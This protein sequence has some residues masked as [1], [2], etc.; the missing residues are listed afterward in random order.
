MLRSRLQN[1]GAAKWG[2]GV[3]LPVP[4]FVTT[5]RCA[6][7]RP[8]TLQFLRLYASAVNEQMLCDIFG[9]N[10]KASFPAE[11]AL[12]HAACAFAQSP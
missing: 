2:P 9:F 6:S 3:K 8:S 12:S 7:S 11:I 10:C 4:S 5:R 1:Q